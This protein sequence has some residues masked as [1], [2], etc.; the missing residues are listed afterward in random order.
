MQPLAAAIELCARL[1]HQSFVPG[2]GKLG[3]AK[4]AIAILAARRGA[5]AVKRT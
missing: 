5:S 3:P 4:K 2:A 1:D